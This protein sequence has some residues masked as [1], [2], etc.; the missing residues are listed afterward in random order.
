MELN[1]AFFTVIKIRGFGGRQLRPY[2]LCHI[3]RVKI[4]TGSHALFSVLSVP[5]HDRP[6][7]TYGVAHKTVRLILTCVYRI[8]E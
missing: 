7:Q 2:T 5:C 3:R 1:T 4:V 6:V 8:C